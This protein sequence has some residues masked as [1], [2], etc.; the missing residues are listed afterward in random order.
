M[1]Y[2]LGID[3]GKTNVRVGLVDEGG[4]LQHFSKR[5]YDCQTCEEMTAYI[6]SFIDEVLAEKDV[7]MT[8]IQGIGI[9]VPAVVDRSSGKISYGPGFDIYAGQSVVDIFES[10][11]Q[12]PVTADV[13][14]VIA[15]Y[16]ELW[17][18]AGKTC[19]DFAVVT[20][21]TGMGAG[22]VK[23]R[24]VVL[25]RDNL[26]PEFGHWRLS[27]DTAQCN[28]GGIGCLNALISGPALAAQGQQASE[29]GENLLNTLAREHAGI[30]TTA[31]V[32]DAAD[33]GD[34]EALRIIKRMIELFGRMC[35]N[36]GYMDQPKKIVVV[37]GLSERGDTL[38][39]EIQ[40][41]MNEQCWLIHKGLAQC[42]LEFSQ[43][44]DKAGVLGAA[45]MAKIRI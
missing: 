20:W 23:A 22:R 26:F 45:Y 4:E 40:R 21:G 12:R 35:A 41:I 25:G 11:Y 1:N 3:Q 44:G 39:D 9:G 28:C 31:I 33:K 29:S 2:Y 38:L 8:D 14:T 6:I 32:F 24:E 13:D 16:G 42:Q 7:T 17:Q 37:G 10:H 43:L 27:D 5:S 18:G 15:T 34:A 19:D 36:L 30:V